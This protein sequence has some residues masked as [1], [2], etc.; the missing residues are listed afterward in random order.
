MITKNSRQ[1][2]ALITLLVCLQLMFVS[3]AAKNPNLTAAQKVEFEV[4]RDLAAIATANLALTKDVVAVDQTLNLV[5]KPTI[6]SIL[7]Y[8]KLIASLHS[9]AIGVLRETVTGADGK[10]V[11]APWPVRAQKAFT[12]LQQSQELPPD[13][14]VFLNKPQTNAGVAAVITAVQTIQGLVVAILAQTKGVQ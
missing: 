3:C 2:V 14:S 12:I 9:Q 10:P 1:L 13:I 11:L 7:T 5:P 8:N 4:N 6:N